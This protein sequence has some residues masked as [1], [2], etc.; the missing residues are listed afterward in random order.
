MRKT[1]EHSAK[2]GFVLLIVLVTVIALSLAAWS[3]SL[4]MVSEDQVTRLTGRQIQ[5][6]YLV[7]SGVDFTRMMLSNDEATI[8]EMG[9]TWD[10]PGQFQGIP[11]SINPTRPNEIGRFSIVAPGLDTEGN[12]E[13]LRFGLSDE[14]S[15]LNVNTLIHAD[16]WVPGGGRQLL[17]SLPLMTEDVADAILDWMDEDDDLREYGSEY[18]YY[19]GLSPPYAPKNGPM[20][21]LEELLLVRGVTPQLLFGLDNNHNGVLDLDEKYSDDAGSIPPEMQLG[22]VN[23]LTLFSKESNLN[24]SGLERININDEDL[25]QLYDD[26]RSVFDEEW[27]NFIMSTSTFR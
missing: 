7:E 2:S 12:L 19:A 3:F 22:W 17:M 15:K 6:R 1:F 18:N 11:V 14:S 10:N 25:A 9:G 23:Y 13:G 24:P 8:R 4:L 26:L 16:G 27:T 5:S 20:D 21:S